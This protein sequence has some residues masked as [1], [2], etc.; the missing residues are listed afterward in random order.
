VWQNPLGPRGLSLLAVAW[1][2]DRALSSLRYRARQLFAECAKPSRGR[3][4]SRVHIC[5]R[6]CASVVTFVTFSDVARA[7]CLAGRLRRRSRSHEAR[8]AST[9]TPAATPST[10]STAASVPL[11]SPHALRKFLEACRPQRMRSSARSHG[12]IYVHKREVKLD[13]TKAAQ[14]V[15]QRAH[16]S[17]LEQHNFCAFARP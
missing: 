15:E 8:S 9:C 3:L 14:S 11:V 12:E 2:Q 16:A 1:A 7:H 5:R 13:E 17:R 4:G 10:A 6:T